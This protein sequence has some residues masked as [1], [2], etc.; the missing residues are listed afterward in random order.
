[1]KNNILIITLAFL[2]TLTS[3]DETYVPKPRAYFKIDYPEKEY[4]KYNNP[5]CPFTFEYPIYSSIMRDS[6]FFDEV[7]TNPCWFDIDFKGFKG[8]IHISY[9]E[10]NNNNLIQLTEDAH[11]LISK[12]TVKADF[13]DESIIET[14]NGV[15]GIM[16]EVGGNAASLMQFY[17]T[18]SARHF[19]RGSL[20]FQAT[21]NSDSIAPVLDFVKEDV[22]LLLGSFHW[23][24]S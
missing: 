23:K 7:Q 8:K 3:C 6:T 19:L 13:I 24:D 11:K 4:M 17:V 9:K 1:M 16:Y 21:P 15:N 5:D 14:E 18:D 22:W 12:H 20:Y 2:F 10:I